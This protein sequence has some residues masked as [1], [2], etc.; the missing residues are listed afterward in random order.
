MNPL[1]NSGRA[2]EID[3]LADVVG[4]RESMKLVTINL[5]L[6]EELAAALG[7]QEG[8]LFERKIGGEYEG[9]ARE[10]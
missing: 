5:I 2:P 4:R 7:R 3:V 6:S 10:R 1:I 8:V 9:H